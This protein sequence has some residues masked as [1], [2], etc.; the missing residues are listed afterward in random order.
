L[1]ELS[2]AQLPTHASFW[3]PDKLL[4]GGDTEGAVVI[5]KADGT[6]MQ[7]LQEKQRYV[8][9]PKFICNAMAKENSYFS[10]LCYNRDV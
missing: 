8:R 6:Y 7:S 1:L 5:Y 3:R 10:A 9:S 4:A 2:V